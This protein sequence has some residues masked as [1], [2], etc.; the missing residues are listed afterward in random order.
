MRWLLLL[1]LVTVT[2][3]LVHVAEAANRALDNHRRGLPPGT[4]AG[5]S[6]MPGMLVM[7]IGF[8]GAAAVVDR[9]WD[10]WGFRVVATLHGIGAFLVLIYVVSAEVRLRR[11][12]GSPN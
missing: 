3:F 5:S 12:R 8:T 1:L 2:W 6:L 9:F 11:A 7:P 4:P 10:P